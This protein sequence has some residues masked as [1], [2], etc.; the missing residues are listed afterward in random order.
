[1]P[2]PGK[3]EILKQ[4]QAASA[5]G[6]LCTSREALRQSIDVLCACL[7]TYDLEVWLI[8]HEQDT[9]MALVKE[10][11]E[12]LVAEDSMDNE[13]EMRKEKM[14]YDVKRST[15]RQ[16]EVV[17]EEHNDEGEGKGKSEGAKEEEDEDEDEPVCLSRLLAKVKGKQPMK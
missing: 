10:L 7:D 16:Q 17:F 14:C 8:L 13:V 6:M 1:M 11:E 2:E 9:C 5:I 15:A 4:V 12:V 3:S